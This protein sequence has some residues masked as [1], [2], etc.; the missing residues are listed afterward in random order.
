MGNVVILDELT[1]NKIAAGEVI[2]RPASVVKELIE[3][4]IDAGAT[5]IDVEIAAGGIRLIRVTDNGCGFMSD[6]ALIAFDKHATSKIR[7]AEDLENV[8]TLGFRGEA[9]ASIAAVAEVTLL[10]KTKDADTGVTVRIK[11]GDPE[12]CREAGC[13]NGTSITVRDLFYNT[14]ARYKFLKRDSTEAGYVA[15]VLEKMAMARPDISFSLTANDKPVMKTPGNGDLV[16]TIYSIFGKQ[17]AQSI[18]KADF[19]SPDG[20][21]KVSGYIGSSGAVYK[22]RARQ[23]FY[24]N[25]RCVKNR[26]LSVALDESVKTSVMKGS[27]PF[28]VLMI[29][30]PPQSLDV[31]VHPMK[32]EVRFSDESAVFSG[33]YTAVKSV[34]TGA[35]SVSDNTIPTYSQAPLQ[36]KYDL[37]N[38]RLP[39][40]V[41]EQESKPYG[42]KTEEKQSDAHSAEKKASSGD[43]DAPYHPD[44]SYEN[45]GSSSHS[46]GYA[47][48]AGGATHPADSV[49]HTFAQNKLNFS[50]DNKKAIRDFLE[51][52][53]DEDLTDKPKEE[54]K[55]NL[56][57]NMSPLSGESTESADLFENALIIGQLFDTFILLQKGEN[58]Y[59]IDQ[60][61]AHERLMYEDIKHI[62]ETKNYNTQILLTPITVNLSKSEF[63]LVSG[64]LDYFEKMGF[65]IENFGGDTL[66]VRA[67]PSILAGS[68]IS[69][70][71]AEGIACMEEGTEKKFFS[72]KAVYT[73]ACKAAVKG[74]THLDHS[75]IEALLKRIATLSG[76]ATCPHGRPF[77]FKFTRQ[78][79]DKKFKR[80]V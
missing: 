51:S 64:N 12:F 68:D 65:E 69:A 71:I 47:S 16:S 1:A 43:F 78:D 57:I 23:Y 74:N 19:E 80:I 32:T 29:T 34:F 67:V 33:I 21:V 48:T 45:T 15:D 66:I 7:S 40:F 79:L 10:S 41:S 52:I 44:N 3:N 63:G 17:V 22:T 31:N 46:S 24:V 77:Y 9:L 2:E 6:D 56:L 76:P 5:K 60:H 55:P 53:K 11:G 18:L 35:S 36:Q 70:F 50:E 37:E 42:E 28:A 72:D 14:P 8:H 62:I 73:M 26:F 13:S 59:L 49:P 38:V 4:S 30:V 54:E 61:A 27:F 39:F 20:K 75:E 25:G 58:A